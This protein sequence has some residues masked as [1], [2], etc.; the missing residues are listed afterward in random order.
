MTMFTRELSLSGP[1]GALETLVEYPQDEAFSNAPIGSVVIAHPHPLYGGTM[2]NK[3]VQTLARAYQQAGW[4][5]VRFNFRGVGKSA[6]VHNQGVGE[7]QD[8]L[9]VIRQST[10]PSDKLAVAGFSFGA[11]MTAH[12]IA[13]LYPERP[14]CAVTLVA[15]AVASF[16]PPPIAADLHAS[17]LV[18]H[19]ESD[20]VAPLEQTLNWVR[21]QALPVT[22]MPGCGHFFHGQLPILKALVT[23]HVRGCA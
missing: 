6:G 20:D 4:R 2:Q 19:G 5:T 1:A 22:V 15:A 9:A 23:R 14:L 11:C 10:F 18:I 8:M 7:V 13:H 12:V 21:E 3:V 17:T 16:Q